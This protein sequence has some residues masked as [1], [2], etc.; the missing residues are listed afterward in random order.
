MEL[1]VI[2]AETLTAQ[3]IKSFLSQ[4]K[5]KKCGEAGDTQRH[6]YLFHIKFKKH[7]PELQGD[8]EI[9]WVGDEEN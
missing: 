4:E 6:K 9:H 1:K 7:F 8:P 2:P 3:D 5:P